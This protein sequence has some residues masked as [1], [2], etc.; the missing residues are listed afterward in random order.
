ML[1]LPL[2]YLSCLFFIH[3]FNKSALNSHHISKP[4]PTPSDTNGGQHRK[5]FCFYQTLQ[6]E[7]TDV[8]QNNHAKNVQMCTELLVRKKHKFMSV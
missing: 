6:L 5:K 3:S 1:N 2:H 7:G 4:M 8:K